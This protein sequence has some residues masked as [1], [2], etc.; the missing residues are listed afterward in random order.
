[1]NRLKAAEVDLN[2]MLR[3][4]NELITMM[5]IIRLRNMCTMVFIKVNWVKKARQKISMLNKMKKL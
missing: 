2:E 4:T 5:N 1:M 3:T